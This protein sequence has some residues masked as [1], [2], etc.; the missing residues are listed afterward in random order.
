MNQPQRTARDFLSLWERIKVR[1]WL[2]RP[3]VREIFGERRRRPSGFCDP[4][5]AIDSW[6]VSSSGGRNRWGIGSL[7]SSVWK[8][9]WRLSWMGPATPFQQR[10]QWTSSERLNCAMPASASS[11]FGMAMCCAILMR[12]WRQFS[13]S[14]IHK[15]RPGHGWIHPH[16]NPLPEAE[17]ENSATSWLILERSRSAAVGLERLQRARR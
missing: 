12:S 7:I 6:L 9:G 15:D 4:D 16:L 2:G 10:K 3:R 17:E 13:W 11:G 8:S 1:A 14:L 5:Y